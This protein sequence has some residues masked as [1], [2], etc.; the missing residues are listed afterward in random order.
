[1]ERYEQGIRT[2]SSEIRNIILSQ[3]LDGITSSIEVRE[4]FHTLIPNHGFKSPSRMILDILET[5]VEFGA[6][7]H[8]RKGAYPE[9]D[10]N[11]WRVTDTGTFFQPL[12]TFSLEKA[13]EYGI[14][15]NALLSTSNSGRSSALFRFN[16]LNALSTTPRSGAELSDQLDVS[17]GVTSVH[18]RRLRQLGVLTFEDPGRGITRLSYTV[19]SYSPQECDEQRVTTVATYLLEHGW[20]TMT[21]LEQALPYARST[22]QSIFTTLRER[23]V[24][25]TSKDRLNLNNVRLTPFGRKL[26][27]GFVLPVHTYLTKGNAEAIRTYEKSVAEVVDLSRQALALYVKHSPNK[28]KVPWEEARNDMLAAVGKSTVTIDSLARALGLTYAGAY[29]RASRLIEE[30]ALLREK[31]QGIVHYFQPP[32]N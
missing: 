32:K 18:L 3:C 27:Q 15:M 2:I 9:V 12:S 24:L 14:P 7:E 11:Y 26:Q 13:V 28:R 20:T 23:N 16:F 4:A 29:A 19:E 22:I 17:Q 21:E 1:M 6:I 31:E 30:G 10:T 25:V 5:L 8:V